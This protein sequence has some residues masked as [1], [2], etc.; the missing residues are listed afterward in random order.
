[1]NKITALTILKAT[2]CPSQNIGVICKDPRG[3]MEEVF[4]TICLHSPSKT[5]MKSGS[6]NIITWGGGRIFFRTLMGD[7]SRLRGYRFDLML[8]EGDINSISEKELYECLIPCLCV[9]NHTT[10]RQ[11]V[12]NNFEGGIP[13][14][15]T[16]KPSLIF[17][18]KKVYAKGI[19][20]AF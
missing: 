17:T 14:H 16:K 9:S 12:F 1:M 13:R 6:E 8:V 4:K 10:I 2:D 5:L 18:E 20:Y 15:W 11:E 3:V 7:S 19:L